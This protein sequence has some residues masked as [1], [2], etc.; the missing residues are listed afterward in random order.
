MGQGWEGTN[1]G[2]KRYQQIERR[3]YT[4]GGGGDEDVRG[5]KES[6]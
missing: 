2:S 3:E 4:G 5:R 1:A 6:E